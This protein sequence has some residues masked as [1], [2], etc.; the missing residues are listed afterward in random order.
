MK[1]VLF[2][3]LGYLLKLV[4]YL[5]KYNG[6]LYLFHMLLTVGNKSYLAFL[7][8]V[9][10]KLLMSSITKNVQDELNLEKDLDFFSGD[11]TF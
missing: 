9:A 11:T 5:Q 3:F 8:G 4:P 10:V 1:T 7:E 2:R 6:I